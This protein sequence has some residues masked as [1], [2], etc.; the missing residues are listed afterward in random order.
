MSKIYDVR[1]HV[2]WQDKRGQTLIPKYYPSNGSL[3][4]SKLN[5]KIEK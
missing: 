4:A 1:D 3:F 5:A 2:R